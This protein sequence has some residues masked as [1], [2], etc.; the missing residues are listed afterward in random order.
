VSSVPDYSFDV[1]RTDAGLAGLEREWLDLFA[2]SGTQNPFAHPAWMIAWL[3]RFVP[4]AD[5]RRVVVVRRGGEPVALAP[6]FLRRHGIGL[7]GG[8]V[9]Q[10]AGGIPSPADPLTEKSEILLLQRDRRKIMRALIRHLALECDA[11]DW[12]GLTLPAPH[13]WFEHEWLPDAWQ[14]RGAFVVHKGVRTFVVLPLPESWSELR[15]KRNLKEAVRRSTNRLA[16]LGDAVELT[17]AEGERVPAA[18]GTLVDLHRRRAQDGDHLPHDDY[19]RVRGAADFVAEGVGRLAAAGRARIAILSVDGEALAAR[20]LLTSNRSLF[21]SCSGADPAHWRLGA[22]T[23]LVAASIRR[24][25]EQGDE[26]VNFSVTPDSGKLR[27]SEQLAFDHEFLV[28]S[29]SR[30]ARIAFST[31]WQLRAGRVL[32]GSRRVAAARIAVRPD[33][34]PLLAEPE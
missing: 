33:R 10:L 26:L 6:L 19:F 11:W 34:E 7:A 2:R 30:R 23:A 12:L 4:D 27:W 16:A 18:V 28:V 9:L 1:V 31:W 3:R 32:A 22:Q 21:L 8:R 13:G 15:L 25:I 24:A 5:D 14:R 17:F 20:L 29:P